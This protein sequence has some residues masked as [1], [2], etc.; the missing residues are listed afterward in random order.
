M[1]LRSCRIVQKGRVR[2]FKPRSGVAILL[3]RRRPDVTRTGL[4]HRILDLLILFLITKIVSLHL[5]G[6]ARRTRPSCGLNL[7][8][9]FPHP[10]VRVS[11]GSQLGAARKSKES[12]QGDASV[13][14][15]SVETK[16]VYFFA[17]PFVFLIRFQFE[18]LARGSKAL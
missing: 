7:L 9:F 3:E 1:A 2:T 18:S 16:A 12:K 13:L 5:P 14:W 15:Q 4:S 8:I 17:F 10:L 6:P 11:P